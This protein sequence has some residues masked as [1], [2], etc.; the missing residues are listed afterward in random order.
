MSDKPKSVVLAW[1][2]AG[3]CC[4]VSVIVVYKAQQKPEDEALKRRVEVT[5]PVEV[6]KSA[7]VRNTIQDANTLEVT[8][9]IDPLSASN[10]LANYFAAV[11]STN[12]ANALKGVSNVEIHVVVG[13]LVSGDV[14]EDEIQARLELT[15]RKNNI[16]VRA[17]SGFLLWA[18]V[19]G[20]WNTTHSTCTYVVSIEMVEN[21]VTW[22][23]NKPIRI[24]VTSWNDLDFGFAGKAVMKNALLD[25]V[26]AK[27]EKFANDYLSQN[28][29]E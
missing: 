22:R 16:P 15:L 18:V 13:K 10:F 3:L 11:T 4:F 14:S 26:Q 19:D 27:A 9:P 5:N 24:A 28:P 20:F 7:Q 25:S 12:A 23:A 6:P 8:P 1:T 17:K 29:K 2:I 21:T